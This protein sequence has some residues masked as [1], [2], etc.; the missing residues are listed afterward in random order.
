MNINTSFLDFKKKHQNKKNQVIFCKTKCKNNKIIENI[1]NNFLIKKNSFIFESVEKRR[2]RGRY[3]I[4][5]ADPDK[6]WEFSN[7]KI[8]IIENN[9]RKNIK[10]SPYAFLKKLIEN[11]NFPLPKNLPPLCSLLVGYFSYDIIRYIEKIPDK[12]LDDLKIPD[13]RLMR[14]KTIII[15]DNVLKKIYFIK[16][17]FA[18]EKINNYQKYFSELKQ[19]INF[20]ENLAFDFSYKNPI[21]ITGNKKID[22]K[23]NVSKKKFK[24]IEC[25]VIN[26][27]T[28]Y[29]SFKKT[30]SKFDHKLGLVNS[31]ARLRMVT[32]Y[33]VAAKNEGIVVGT[34]N[35]VEDFAIGFFS[36]GG[37]GQVDISPIGDLTKTE[38]WSL[39]EHLEILDEIIKA[40]PT[41]G[42][43]ESQTGHTDVAQIGLTYPELEKA[44]KNPEDKKRVDE[45]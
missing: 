34:G 20:L 19:N 24:N 36:K 32:I 28:V 9:K 29:E 45:D 44:I 33:Q 26:L 1:I 11:F 18:D 13:I 6:I 37:D 27:D 15:H 10:S 8:H 39:A 3:T 43:W 12:C 31:K 16:N 14:P 41:D 42:L 35:A 40:E 4:I 38:V 22:V 30:L 5:G 2:I 23:S 21:Q 17:C 7:K 25:H